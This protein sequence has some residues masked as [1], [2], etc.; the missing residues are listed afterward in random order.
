[1]KRTLCLFTALLLLLTGCAHQPQ[2]HLPT[3]GPVMAGP[4]AEYKFTFSAAR[5]SG[6]FHGDWDIVYTYNGD[7]VQSGY[8]LIFPL[9]IFTFHIVRVDLTEKGNPENTYSTSFRVP[10]YDGG[11]G[12]TQITVAD[13]KGRTVTFRIQCKITQVGE[14]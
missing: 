10:I 7:Q 11:S 13:G 5:Q 6:F 8:R 3:S 14:R 12:E 9:Q 1:M 4:Y 2:A